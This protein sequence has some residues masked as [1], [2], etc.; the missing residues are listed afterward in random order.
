MANLHREPQ[1]PAESAFGFLGRFFDLK[2]TDFRGQGFNGVNQGGDF[3]LTIHQ[4]IN[5]GANAAETGK[6][7]AGAI[8]KVINQSFSD[9]VNQ[10]AI[11]STAH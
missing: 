2:P 9:Y 7:S 4:T 3:N 11:G 10:N 6:E 5:G 8:K 1:G